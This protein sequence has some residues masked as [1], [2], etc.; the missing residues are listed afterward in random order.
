MNVLSI[1]LTISEINWSLTKDVF[2]IIGTIGT[3]T[4]GVVG[5][6]TW[7]RQ[8]RGTSEY[9]LAKKAIFVTYQVRQ[10]IQSVRNPMLQLS[11]EEVEA[12]NKIQEQQRIYNDRMQELYVKWAEL[13]TIRLEAK[14][15]W[16]DAAHDSFNEVE[17]LIGKLRG[18]I[19]LHFWMKGAYAG[20]GST[21]DNSPERV[22]ENDKIIYYI[23]E[24]DEFSVKVN[25]AVA[26]VEAFFQHRV[27]GK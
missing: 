1:C 7:K 6:T 11:R 9:E 22:A 25:E 5:L 15:I 8:L 10:S 21:V 14:V 16:S 19:W 26:E 13:Q 24:D 18:A 4:L 12:G 17:K 23:S 3:I 2:S 20:P 27:R